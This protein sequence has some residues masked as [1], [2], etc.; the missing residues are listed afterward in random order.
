[1]AEAWIRVQAP[2]VPSPGYITSLI[3]PSDSQRE[4][5]IPTHLLP[6]QVEGIFRTWNPLSQ[7]SWEH[8]RSPARCEVP[9]RWET[10]LTMSLSWRHSYHVYDKG[11]WPIHNSCDCNITRAALAVWTRRL[12]ENERGSDSLRLAGTV[13]LGC[14]FDCNLKKKKRKEKTSTVLWKIVWI[15]INQWRNT[16]SISKL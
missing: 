11:L 13:M 1:M 3:R 12:W 7:H 4:G 5:R 10:H 2:R 14:Y 6:K 16:S 15:S 9:E 8:T